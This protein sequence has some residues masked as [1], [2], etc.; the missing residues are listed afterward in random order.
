MR[1][2]NVS[3]NKQAGRFTAVGRQPG[4]VLSINAPALPTEPDRGPTGFSPTELLLAGAG[5][6]S[7]WDV[8]EIL[9]KR[10]ADVDSLDV[11]VEGHQ[12]ADPPWAYRQIAFHYRAAGDGLKVA[13]L[14]RVIR[15]SIV[16]YCSVITTIAGVAAISATVELVD[17]DGTSTG[18]VPI[19]LAI[20][21][22]PLPPD[23]EPLSDEDGL[24]A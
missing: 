1:T 23:L 21:A 6:C 20:P 5:S 9:R 7:L 18:R 12:A 14:A 11:V 2:V 17:R 13:V 19:E 24:P 22:A 4:H 8:V 3:W 16:R 15:L 10:R